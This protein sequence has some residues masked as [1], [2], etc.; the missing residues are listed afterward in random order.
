MSLLRALV[1]RLAEMPALADTAATL[2][3]RLDLGV[4][5][6]GWEPFVRSVADAVSEVVDARESQRR[7]LDDFL[8]QLTQQL[9]D[10]ESWTRWQAGAAQ[11]RRDDAA[12]LEL[13]V[14]AETVHLAAGSRDLAGSRLSENENDRRGSTRSRAS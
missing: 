6:V 1:R 12:G 4:A 9:A 13:T 8:E 14:Q 5:E 2:S 7:E 3:R 11:S 10:L